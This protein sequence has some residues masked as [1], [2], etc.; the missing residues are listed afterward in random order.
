M[1]IGEHKLLAGIAGVPYISQFDNGGW[2]QGHMRDYHE[3]FGI[4]EPELLV[5]HAPIFPPGKAP[6]NWD[7]MDP[8]DW[9]EYWIGVP[10]TYYGH[11]HEDHG[12][13]MNPDKTMEFCN[14]GALLRGSLTEAS[15]TRKPAAT[16]WDGTTFERIEVPH[17]PASEVFLLAQAARKVENKTSALAFAQAVDRTKLTALT[18]DSVLAT[19]RAEVPDKQV[20]AVIEQ[21][22]DETQ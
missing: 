17:K 7:S 13:Y 12:I 2:W 8:E 5:T 19:L 1:L 9:A 3:D 20:L 10:A 4:T 11:I 22:L 16:Y 15:K 6:T 21:V 14:H 18:L